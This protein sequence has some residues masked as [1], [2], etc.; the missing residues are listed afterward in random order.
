[1]QINNAYA[2]VADGK[3]LNDWGAESLGL[4]PVI[5]QAMTVKR[6]SLQ[7]RVFLISQSEIL[8]H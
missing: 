8:N 3:T 4:L 6:G 2:E 5:K 7:A 1:V